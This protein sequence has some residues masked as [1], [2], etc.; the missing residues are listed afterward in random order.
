MVRLVAVVRRP[1]SLSLAPSTLQL[2]FSFWMTR[3][4]SCCM[5]VAPVIDLIVTKVLAALD[6]H[7]ARWIIEKSFKGDLIRERTVLLVVSYPFPLA[8]DYISPFPTHRRRTTS[9]WLAHS[10]TTSFRS[11]RTVRSLA[12]ARSQT[13]SRR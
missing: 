12:V 4:F 2:R 9:R 5:L 3:V 11:A 7:T 1:V 8:S 6:V 13:Y 10:R